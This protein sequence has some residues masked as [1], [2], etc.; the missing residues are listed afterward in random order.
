MSNLTSIVQN[1]I[2]ECDGNWDEAVSRLSNMLETDTE[3]FNDYV[4]PM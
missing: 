1:V 4:R 2:D 3:L